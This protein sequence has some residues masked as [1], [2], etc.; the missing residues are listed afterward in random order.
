MGKILEEINNGTANN[1]SI[2][3]IRSHNY[4]KELKQEQS[5]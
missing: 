4:L 2:G 1:Q 5:V 3:Q